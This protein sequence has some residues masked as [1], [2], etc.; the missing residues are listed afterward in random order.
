[1]VGIC[2][3]SDEDIDMAQLNGT[4][5]ECYDDPNLCMDG[6]VTY[7]FKSDNSYEVYSYGA[8][9]HGK[10]TFNGVYMLE[11][12]TIILNPMMSDS[13]NRSY[14]IIKLN[15]KEMEWQRVGTKYTLGTM[16]S[17]YKHFRRE[18]K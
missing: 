4:W 12:D 16:G 10:K 13:S 8:L 17:D 3:C 1:M 6:I 2:F 15:S 7:T 11:G 14:R 9:S 18:G 5:N